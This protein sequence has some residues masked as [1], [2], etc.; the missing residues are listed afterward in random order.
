MSSG[1]IRIFLKFPIAVNCVIGYNRIHMEKDN[2][3]GGLENN[4]G[5]SGS[6]G[7]LATCFLRGEWIAKKPAQRLDKQRDA[8][9]TNY[10][11]G[12][13]GMTNGWTKKTSERQGTEGDFF[14]R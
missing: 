6:F 4:S 10:E 1:Q 3:L 8:G 12:T 9:L 5:C 2:Y 7:W 14:A 11:L 13:T